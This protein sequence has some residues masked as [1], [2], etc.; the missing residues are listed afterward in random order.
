MYKAF[1]IYIYIC[2]TIVSVA[3][4]ALLIVVTLNLI[5]YAYQSSV[6]FN[7]FRK[8]LKKYNSEMQKE[9]RHRNDK[10]TRRS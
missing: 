6:G 1:E 5:A 10:G 2:A 9:R 3:V 7:T 4:L 8:F